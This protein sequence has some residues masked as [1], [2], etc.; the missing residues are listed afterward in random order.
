L[1]TNH[2]DEAILE[3]APEIRIALIREQRQAWLNDLVRCQIQ[4]RVADALDDEPMRERVRQ[5]TERCIRALDE[6]DG[7]LAENEQR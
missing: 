4:K 1:R 2:T 5:A 7:M 3:I 6:L